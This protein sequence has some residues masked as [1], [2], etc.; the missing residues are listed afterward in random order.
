MGNYPI[1][2]INFKE[3]E[4]SE[5]TF[6]QFFEEYYD[7][8]YN[9]IFFT[10]KNPRHVEDL[11]CEVLEKVVRNLSTYQDTKASINTWIFAITKN[12]LMDYYRTKQ[13]KE[14]IPDQ[15][16]FSRLPDSITKGPVESLLEMER[17]EQVRELIHLLPEQEREMV[18]L[19]FWGGL[20]NVEIASRMRCTP[21]QVNVSVYRSLKKLKI[22]IGE[23]NGKW[24]K[25]FT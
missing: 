25:S 9:Y 24:E 6:N 5:D 20:K 21:N 18:V 10:L 11:T 15:E 12:H 2:E 19:K 13:G 17:Q 8:I 23:G 1:S 3:K 22:A 16:E 7:K 14:A 4:F